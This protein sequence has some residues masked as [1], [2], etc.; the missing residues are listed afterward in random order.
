ML[1]LLKFWG[2]KNPQTVEALGFQPLASILFAGSGG[3]EGSRTLLKA[4][5]A[6]N[7]S[8]P[9]PLCTNGFKNL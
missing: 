2:I 8:S 7:C 5:T 4:F 1:T 9:K 6:F 3:G